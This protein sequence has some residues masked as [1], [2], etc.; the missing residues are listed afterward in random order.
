MDDS[1]LMRV[2]NATKGCR[3]RDARLGWDAAWDEAGARIAR[4]ERENKQMR[5][6]LSDINA[7]PSNRCNNAEIAHFTDSRRA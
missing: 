2:V 5:M 6:A 1:G 4:L 3:L 7:L